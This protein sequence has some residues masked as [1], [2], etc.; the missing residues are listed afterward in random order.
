VGA[1]DDMAESGILGGQQ[2]CAVRE[3]YHTLDD[4]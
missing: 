3:V 4:I 2:V 1:W